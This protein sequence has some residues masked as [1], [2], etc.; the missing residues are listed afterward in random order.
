[1]NVPTY[2]PQRTW[3]SNDG[4]AVIDTDQLG[5]LTI[6]RSSHCVG[7]DRTH[8]AV[9]ARLNLRH[10][11]PTAYLSARLVDATGEDPDPDLFVSIRLA[12][13]SHPTASLLDAHLSIEQAHTLADHLALALAHATAATKEHAPA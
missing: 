12:D 6:A 1:M 11:A 2:Q 13:E 4:T 3:T 10:R 5:S 9:A 7:T 8:H